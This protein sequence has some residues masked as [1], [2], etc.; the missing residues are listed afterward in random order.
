[1]FSGKTDTL[2]KLV[3]HA[4]AS[5]QLVGVL[6]PSADFRSPGEIVSHAGRRHSAIIVSGP[7]DVLD[8]AAA[9]DM[10]AVDEAQ[11]LDNETIAAIR[12]LSDRSVPVIAAGLDLDYRAAPFAMVEALRKSADEVR[13]L[14]AVCGLCGRDATHTQRFEN[15][16]PG[17]PTGPTVL[18]GGAETYQPRCQECY[19]RE[20]E[21]AGT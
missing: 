21:Q 5:G 8:A 10:V 1:M 20:R 6:K 3:E 17:D 4:E 2:L 11:F 18:I 9:S 14:T 13:Q 7:S 15:G 19:F 12:S 16:L